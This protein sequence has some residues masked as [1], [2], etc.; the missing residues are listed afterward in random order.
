ML[1][2][3][4]QRLV[5]SSPQVERMA[6]FYRDA[7]GYAVTVSGGRYQCEGEG[8]SLWI[9]HGAANQ[10]IESHFV[11]PDVQT[12]RSYITR[13]KG[14][15]IG[16]RIEEGPGELAVEIQDPENRRVRFTV[17]GSAA[18]RRHLP[19]EK[20]VRPARLQHYAVRTPDVQKLL[21][22]Y[23]GS[24][25]FTL[26]DIVRDEAG[27]LTAAFLRTDSEHHAFA[28]FRAAQSRLDHFSC[29]TSDW[30]ALRDWADHMAERTVK[31]VWGIGRH[32]PGNDTFFMV[33]DPDE[34][35]AEISSDLE[36][37]PEDRSVGIWKH[38]METLNQWGLAIM[39]S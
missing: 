6:A 35:L 10:L 18:G 37:C 38:R 33:H 3:H 9:E 24:L 17:E 32:G 16:C 11:V 15:G 13:L 36:R 23:S 12:L 26:S 30:S 20:N 27:E 5:I 22:F 28:I 29:E 14:R 7:F 2:A 8:R 39:R 4:L 34:N 21:E 19:S 1:N 25:G 31:L